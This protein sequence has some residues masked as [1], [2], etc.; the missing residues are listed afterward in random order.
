MHIKYFTGISLLLACTI[1]MNSCSNKS[2]NREEQAMAV[3]VAKAETDS[4]VLYRTYPGVLTAG[5]KVTIV[6]RVNGTIES[7]NYKGGDLVKKGQ[8]LFTI[9][10]SKYRDAVQ[11][12]RAAL[13]TALSTREYA[14]AHYA[15]MEKAM[16]SNAVSVMEMKEAK[17]ALEQA[18][19]SISNARAALQTANTNLSYCRIYAPVTGRASSNDYGVGNYVNGEG[20]PVK[21]ATIY[22]DSYLQANFSIE[23]ASFLRSFAS[24]SAR[25]NINYDSIPIAFTEQ[26]PHSYTGKLHYMAPDV[27]SSTGT[28]TVQAEVQNPYNELRDGMFVN[29]SLPYQMN[30]KA[31]LIKD[32]SIST[33]QLGKFVYVVN[34]SNRIV[35]TPITV[36]GIVRDS[37]RV[38]TK[39]LEPGAV[40][41]T[42]ALLKVRTGIE[43]KPVMTK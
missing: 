30:P 42:K 39:G 31:I 20:A 12:A 4:V 28:M 2:D 10:S 6:A 43:V 17:S 27:D 34:D 21:V 41:V 8:L 26:L 23:D 35:Y 3:D 22:N 16:K 38:V 13:Q 7:V 32:S 15:A 1:T 40:Y 37:M 18:E 33:D 29:V 25:E 36:G 5:D 9:E 11:Q 24:Q 14:A 19:A